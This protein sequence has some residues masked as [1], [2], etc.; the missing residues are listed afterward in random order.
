MGGGGG[1]AKRAKS[2]FFSRNRPLAADDKFRPFFGS[3]LLCACSRWWGQD[4]SGC[5]VGFMVTQV[6]GEKSEF[7]A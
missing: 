1:G 5:Q 7:S 2:K 4:D 3:V 6:A